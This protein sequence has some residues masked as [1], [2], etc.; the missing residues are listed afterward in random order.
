[1]DLESEETDIHV[2]I[3]PYA[4]EFAIPVL[5]GLVI[6]NHIFP[7]GRPTRLC[8]AKSLLLLRSVNIIAAFS[9]LMSMKSRASS[10]RRAAFLMTRSASGQRTRGIYGSG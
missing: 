2:E 3:P 4:H 10:S 5:N 7:T 1:M 6:L 8:G 9:T